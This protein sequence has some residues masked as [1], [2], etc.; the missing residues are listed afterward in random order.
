[1]GIV[2]AIVALLK[3]VPSLERL[4]L[5][6]ADGI[7]EA[8]AKG[9]YDEKLTHIDNAIRLAGG[10]RDNEGTEWSE[11]VDRSPPVPEGGTVRARVDE[12]GIEESRGTGI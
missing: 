9:R 3:A 7:R 4:F 12:G 10:V 11:G 5:K 1:M 2:S 6:V 8:K